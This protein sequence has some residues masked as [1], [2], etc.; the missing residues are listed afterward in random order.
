M[1]FKAIGKITAGI[2]APNC[3]EFWIFESII[4]VQDPLLHTK[5]FTLAKQ[6]FFA[7]KKNKS[8]KAHFMK[9]ST[10]FKQSKCNM[11]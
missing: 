6:H 7:S 1:N 9:S 11:Q 8:T 4:Y 2:N 5:S 10:K 3:F